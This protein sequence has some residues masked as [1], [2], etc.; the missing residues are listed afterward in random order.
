M[1]W[2]RW[3]LTRNQWRRGGAVGMRS[4][5]MFLAGR[6]ACWAWPAAWPAWRA[7]TLGLSHASP[8]SSMLAWDVL[9]AVFLFFWTIGIITELQ[10]SEI[11]DVG[12]LLHLPVSL[13]DV[14]LLNYA[15][16]HLSF[17]LAL[18]LP[19]MLGLAVGLVLARGP[20][21]AAAVPVG[22]RLLLHDHGLDVLPAEL[23]GGADGQQAPPAGHRL[24]R[25]DGVR[26]AH[27]I[28]QP[29]D[30]R[31]GPR[32]TRAR[33]PARSPVEVESGR[34]L[35]GERRQTLARIEA[36]HRYVPLLWLPQGAEALAQD[37]V[38]PAVWG[39]F[40]MA[41]IGALGTG[42]GLPRRPPLLPGRRD[43]GTCPAAATAIPAAP[44][45]AAVPRRRSTLAG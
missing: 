34:R 1:L 44:P 31:R 10:R 22:V 28:A 45:A 12:R 35:A 20:G 4:S 25:H 5:L 21:M 30:E 29:A 11:I 42:P 38:W 33:R 3:R 36:V 37:N 2:L 8:E 15:A 40:G 24:R 14:F 41:A 6:T 17:S 13:R 23:A 16:S 43:A 19:A 26:P 39:A 7:A 9:V 18:T 27:A 32:R